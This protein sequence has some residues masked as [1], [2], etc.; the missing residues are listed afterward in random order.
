MVERNTSAA[1]GSDNHSHTRHCLC[2]RLVV[3]AEF[4]DPDP[5]HVY[6][7]TLCGRSWLVG[8]LIPVDSLV[9]YVTQLALAP[10]KD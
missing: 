1:L 2:C 4:P 5:P 8:A 7:C 3:V 9:L 6:R 10:V